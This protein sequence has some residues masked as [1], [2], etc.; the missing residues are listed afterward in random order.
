MRAHAGMRA[1]RDGTHAQMA[2]EPSRTRI[3]RGSANHK[4]INFSH[5]TPKAALCSAAASLGPR[6]MRLLWLRILSR[7]KNSCGGSTGRQPI[8]LTW[9]L[10]CGVLAKILWEYRDDCTKAENR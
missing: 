10:H 3:Q 8:R 9:P 6:I 4:M 5:V 7:I 1:A 2:F